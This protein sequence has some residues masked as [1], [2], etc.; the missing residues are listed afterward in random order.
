MIKPQ[1]QLVKV[2]EGNMHIRKMG[3]RPVFM[4]RI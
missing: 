2:N 3:D 1:G 4:L